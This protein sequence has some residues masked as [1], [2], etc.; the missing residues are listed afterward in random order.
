[1]L[2]RKKKFRDDFI[3]DCDKKMRACH[4]HNHTFPATHTL[5]GKMRAV[6]TGLINY[7]GL[8]E[9]VPNSVD[10]IP[11]SNLVKSSHE[12]S[13]KSRQKTQ[14]NG[15]EKQSDRLLLA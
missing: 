14:E 9:P 15:E 13:L 11:V 1:M 7:T 3:C 5:D 4:H 8:K 2:S 10:L 12:S 6:I